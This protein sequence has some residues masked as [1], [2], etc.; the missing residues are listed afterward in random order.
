[1]VVGRERKLQN[2]SPVLICSWSTDVAP[3]SI[4]LWCNSCYFPFAVAPSSKQPC[5]DVSWTRR[6]HFQASPPEQQERMEHEDPC[7]DGCHARMEQWIHARP[8]LP[9]NM[10]IK[11][12]SNPG[13]FVIVKL[14]RSTS[15]DFSVS[16]WK[17]TESGPG[18]DC[19][20]F[21]HC[22][23]VVRCPD[24]PTFQSYQD[25]LP[26][27][28]SK[29]HSLEKHENALFCCSCDL[30]MHGF[31]QTFGEFFVGGY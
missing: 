17:M 6:H 25:T 4:V 8:Q 2:E 3:L 9:N 26:A 12:E 10:E 13:A 27:R 21:W 31:F 18:D 11:S 14:R 20:S 22:R 29:H 24:L 5:K 16:P 23:K 19:T 1:M 15:E 30:N 28:P 7:K